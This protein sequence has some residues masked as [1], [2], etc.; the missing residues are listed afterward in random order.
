MRTYLLSYMYAQ[1]IPLART[2]TKARHLKSMG[3]YVISLSYFDFS[4]YD[5]DRNEKLMKLIDAIPW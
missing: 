5:D 1:R 2:I 3:Y 4:M